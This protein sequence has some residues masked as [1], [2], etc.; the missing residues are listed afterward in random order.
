MPESNILSRHDI[1]IQRK[2]RFRID[3]T[4]FLSLIKGM[5]EKANFTPWKFCP[6]VQGQDK[7]DSFP[8]ALEHY[9]EHSGHRIKQEKEIKGIKNENEERKLSTVTDN[10]PIY[11]NP[12][13]FTKFC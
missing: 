12:K 11:R 1:T 2:N 5:Y 3:G 9:T 7:G 4:S 6:Q 8:N 13:E 10:N